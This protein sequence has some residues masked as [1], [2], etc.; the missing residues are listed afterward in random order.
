MKAKLLALIVSTFGILPA[1]VF[2]HVA[3]R[4]VIVNAMCQVVQQVGSPTGS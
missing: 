4:Q 1:L 3:H 2:V